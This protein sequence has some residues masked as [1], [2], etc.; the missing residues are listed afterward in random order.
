MSLKSKFI[1]LTLAF[2]AALMG[3][4]VLGSSVTQAQSLTGNLTLQGSIQGNC[5]I[6]VT[7]LPAASTL[8]LTGTHE[9]VG[10]GAIHVGDISQTCNDSAGF[11]LTITSDH[12]SDSP[13]GGK[14][15]GPGFPGDNTH[16]VAYTISFVN[17]DGQVDNLLSSC[18]GQVAR[19][20]SGTTISGD[21]SAIWVSYDASG[22]SLV[23]GNFSDTLTI[24]MNLK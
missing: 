16:Y 9:G 21:T 13:A 3:A 12:C 17:P 10:S 4:S 14:L 1:A 7:A 15:E 23:T 5:T 18:S 6:D 24:T 8:S 11:T 20:V 2:A 19:N 22:R